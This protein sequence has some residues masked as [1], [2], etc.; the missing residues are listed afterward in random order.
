MR[1][2]TTALLALCFSGFVY[3]TDEPKTGNANEANNSTI[4]NS[5]V[6]QAGGDIINN[7]YITTPKP[8]PATKPN[9]KNKATVAAVPKVKPTN[10]DNNTQTIGT[11][12]AEKIVNINEMKGNLDMGQ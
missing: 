6:N 9:V 2:I 11:E 3:A 8:S 5:K 10:S 12:T 7:T 1:K 4:S